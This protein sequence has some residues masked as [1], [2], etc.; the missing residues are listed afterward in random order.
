[1]SNLGEV[2][3]TRK[4][5]MRALFA[6]GDAYSQGIGMAPNKKASVHLTITRTY[7]K[8]GPY[9]AE[10]C[11]MSR[12]NWLRVKTSAHGPGWR[13][14]QKKNNERCQNSKGS[15]PTRAIKKALVKLAKNLR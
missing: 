14:Y 3:R 12:K 4:K 5:V 9:R 7:E 1:M 8:G 6:R 10:A 2:K 15:T 13:T 11:M